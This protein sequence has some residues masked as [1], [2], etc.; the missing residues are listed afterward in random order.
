M[1]AAAAAGASFDELM[2]LGQSVS[3]EI[4][5]IAATLDHCHVPGRTEHAMLG[6]NEIELGTGPH[7]EPV[8]DLPARSVMHTIDH[9]TGLQKDLTRTIRLRLPRHRPEIL[10]RR[11]RFCKRLCTL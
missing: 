11:K 2:S 8:G 9:L 5:S 10:P 1:G 6:E 3:K 4:A 7:N